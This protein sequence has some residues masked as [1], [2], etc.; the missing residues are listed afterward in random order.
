M[1]AGD[2][3]KKIKVEVSFTDDGGTLE[4]PDPSAAYPSNAPVAAAAGACPADNDWCTTLTVGFGSSGPY[5]NY[6][7]GAS[8]SDG[9]LAN[10]TID[11]GDGTTWM[12]SDMRIR[13]GPVSDYIYI[14]L[15]AFLPRG[16]VFDLGGTTFTVE[17]GNELSTTGQYELDLPAGFAWVH[18]QDVT[19]SVKLPESAPASGAPEI[20]GTPQVGE[21]LTAG[22]GDIADL[23]GLPT[24]F[25]DDYTLQWI[26][27]DANGTSNPVDVGTD[28][29]D[30]TLVAA[31]EGKRIKVKVTFTDDAANAEE[32]TSD[33]YPTSSLRSYPDFGI[34]PAQTDCPAGNDWCA[35][36]TVG[37]ASLSGIG[38]HYGF[39]ASPSY[40][41][42]DDTSFDLRRVDLHGRRRS[43][44]GSRRVAR[45]TT[46]GSSSTPSCRGARCSS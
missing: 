36:M 44:S 40:G 9:A 34:P 6:G 25:P 45:T 33:V 3:G 11:D 35:T 2:V 5:K 27:V 19:V 21:T 32:L 38:V 26:R 16:S 15:D 31:D 7:L 10:T 29:E 23:D 4:E 41:A 13:N 17:A 42:L 24:T 18:G 28:D 8:I 1:V 30:Y 14:Y 43:G 20:S 37:Y 22:I 46:S 39:S 12:V